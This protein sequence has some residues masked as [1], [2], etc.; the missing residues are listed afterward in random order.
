MKFQTVLLILATITSQVGYS[1]TN[2]SIF[3][4]KL[5]SEALTKGECY[6]NLRYLCTQI[7]GRLS[8]SPQAEQAVTYTYNLMKNNG[9]D[10]VYLQQVMV[11]HWVRGEKETAWVTKGKEQK[12]MRVCALGNSVGTG[13]NGIEAPVV[14]VRNFD[15][16]AKLG[17][18]YI[19]GK[20]VFFNRPMNPE[21]IQTGRAYGEAGNQ[22]GQGPIEAAKYGAIGVIVRSLTLANDT[23][24]H[25]GMTNYVDSIPKIPACAISTVDADELSMLLKLKSAGSVTFYFRQTCQ[26]YPDVLSY[27]VIGE[28][29]GTMN[30]EEIIVVGGH[31]DSWDNGQ[32]AH[33]DGAGV[34]QSIEALRLL[35]KSGYKPKR[36]IRCVLFMNE[37]NGVRGGIEYATLAKTQKHLAAIESDAGGFTPRGFGVS[38]TSA[39]LALQQFVPLLK[40]YD[41][42]YIKQG[43]GGTDIGPL[44]KH[45]CVLIGYIPDSQRYFDYHHT[46]IDT[47][48]KIN[49]RELELGAA[50]ISSLAYIISEY[51]IK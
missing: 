25:T 39:C 9:F 51:G 48:D 50:A 12:R 11:P 30:P 26:Q 3:I 1:Q 29:K 7:G 49:K 20:I 38:D 35:Q 46:A 34:V 14:E 22:R 31:L 8:G 47:F 43:G 6:Q 13:P 32:G 18:T 10:T 37:E 21:Y 33:D 28:L 4:R 15:E 24:P 42:D 2:D 36:T 40:P 5:Y 27:N 23:N 41:I 19:S 45:G 16:L 17:R 44:R